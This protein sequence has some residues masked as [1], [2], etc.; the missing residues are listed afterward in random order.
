MN[1]PATQANPASTLRLSTAAR[2]APAQASVRKAAPA[3][4][5]RARVAGP[6]GSMSTTVSHAAAPSPSVNAA[7]AAA[8]A[9]TRRGTSWDTRLDR[10]R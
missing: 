1:V 9:V 2:R 6:I 10:V 3:A 8:Q 4:Q 5:H 7:T